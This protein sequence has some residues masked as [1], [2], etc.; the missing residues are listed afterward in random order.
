M[1]CIVAVTTAAIVLNCYKIY[2]IAT[3]LMRQK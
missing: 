2:Y 3:L 1:D